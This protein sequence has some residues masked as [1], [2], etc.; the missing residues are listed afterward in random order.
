[1]R[2]EKVIVQC[3][4]CGKS[5]E[6]APYRVKNSKSHFCDLKCRKERDRAM[7]GMLSPRYSRVIRQCASCG[8][9][10]FVPL[11]KIKKVKQFFCNHDCRC[12]YRGR[13]AE[14]PCGTCGKLLKRRPSEIKSRRR[15]FCDLVC[16]AEWMKT[17]TGES[18]PHYEGAQAQV[19]C[20]NCGV[21][22]ARNRREM[23]DH[24]N[25]FCCKECHA[26]WQDA[27]THG[28]N[29]NSWKGGHP[30]Y[31]GP[32]W[33]E[34]KRKARR[35][36]GYQCQACG[37]RQRYNKALHVHHIKPLRSFNCNPSDASGYLEANRLE[38]LISLCASCHRK[39]ENRTL[40]IWRT[41]IGA[42][43]D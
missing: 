33:D 28:A 3:A 4:N 24:K 19:Q 11:N 34:Q 21:S 18:S 12:D 29:S 42:S 5:L 22:F 39:V 17:Q 32:N 38:N 26:K 41:P 23:K 15:H 37:E 9:D 35:R 8:K 16:R 43:D 14:V 40:L 2:K 10:V 30:A 6:V 7:S 1:M 13:S 20:D 27:H 36:D 31:Y 25:H